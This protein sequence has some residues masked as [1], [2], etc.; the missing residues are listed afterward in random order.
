MKERENECVRMLAR[1]NVKESV[2]EEGGR[3]C[4]L[5]HG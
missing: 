5:V 2:W 1:G 3:G 4:E